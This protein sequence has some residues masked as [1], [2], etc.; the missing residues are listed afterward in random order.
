[1]IRISETFDISVAIEKF[2][3]ASRIYRVLAPYFHW[4]KKKENKVILK[5]WQNLATVC[6]R[7]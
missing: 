2:A 1:M 3:R 4:K 7:G 5:D 6:N